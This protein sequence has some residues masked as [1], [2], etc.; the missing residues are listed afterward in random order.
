MGRGKGVL[1]SDGGTAA[2]RLGRFLASAR[3]K[4]WLSRVRPRTRPPHRARAS[5]DDAC[6]VMYST[7]SLASYAYVMLLCI[8]RNMHTTHARMHILASSPRMMDIAHAYSLE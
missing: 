5:C 6:N 7:S 3:Q 4:A 8:S 1:T 2:R